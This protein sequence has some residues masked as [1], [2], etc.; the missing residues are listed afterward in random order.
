[1]I[2]YQELPRPAI[3]AHRGSSARA[4]E[5]TLAAF[6][7]ALQ[8]ECDGIELDVMLSGDGQIV[9]I[10]DDDL[11]RTTGF[12]GNVANLPVAVIKQLDAGS[13]FDIEFRNEKIPLLEEV[14][15]QLGKRAFINV[16]LKNYQ[17]IFDNLPD[18]VSKLVI[19]FHLQNSILFSS[20]NPIALIKIKRKIP[21][22]AIGLLALPGS[23]GRWARSW[24]GWALT[25]Y[26]AI[27]P[28]KQDITRKLIQRAHVSSK[29]VH[30]Y[31]VNSPEEVVRLFDLNIDGIFTDDPLSA[32]MLLT[33]QHPGASIPR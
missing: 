26:D 30:A 16:E 9:V 22:A 25:R 6:E 18:L 2:S 21:N 27:H 14:F 15:E 29:R 12:K 7:L 13:Y 28:E 31:T 24:P 19:G 20:F 8:H 10:H 33:G 11:S 32:R 5:N 23:A 1:M 4:P 17:S 3:F